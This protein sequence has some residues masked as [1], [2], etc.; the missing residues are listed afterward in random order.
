MADAIGVATDA[1]SA[2]NLADES[3]LPSRQFGSVHGAHGATGHAAR[4]FCTENFFYVQV[5]A[6]GCGVLCA[7]EGAVSDFFLTSHVPSVTVRPLDSCLLPV[8][9]VDVPG[10]W[11]DVLWR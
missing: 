1:T 4:Q 6:L 9:A 3:C 11:Q 7:R 10:V 2:L 8:F 5:L